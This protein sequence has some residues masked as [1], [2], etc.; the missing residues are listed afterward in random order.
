MRF[1]RLLA[2]TLCFCSSAFAI[3]SGQITTDSIDGSLTYLNQGG[4]RLHSI[5]QL[6]RLR[7]PTRHRRPNHQ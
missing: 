1:I 6:R 5:H 7:M 2:V 4:D 3:S